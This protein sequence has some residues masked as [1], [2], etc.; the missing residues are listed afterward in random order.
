VRGSQIAR[1]V[2]TWDAHWPVPRLYHVVGRPG[3]MV[4]AQP[5]QVTLGQDQRPRPAVATTKVTP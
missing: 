3:P 1:V 2:K 5:T 4:A